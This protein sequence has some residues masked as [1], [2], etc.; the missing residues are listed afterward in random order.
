MGQS[1]L[2][3]R[4]WKAINQF[5]FT[6]IELM[7]VVGIVGILA[8]LAIPNFARYQSKARQA[9]AK[10]ALSSIYAGEKAFYAEYSGYLAAHDAIGY[11]PEGFKRF[12]SVGWS[13]ITTATITGFSG[14]SV[15]YQ[16]PMINYPPLWTTCD[17]ESIAALTPTITTNDSQTFS[18]GAAGQ[19]RDATSCDI[20]TMDQEK[21]LRNTQVNL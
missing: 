18:V 16:Y 14:V 21:D 19:V 17:D 3:P 20:W 8:A 10:I 13:A 5:G 9:E 15:T 1:F 4:S 11:I 6:L 7:I 12:Y 2:R